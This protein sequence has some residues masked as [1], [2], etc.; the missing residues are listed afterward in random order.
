[1]KRHAHVLSQICRGDVWG[2][3]SYFTQLKRL[4]AALFTLE[5][6]PKGLSNTKSSLYVLTFR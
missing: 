6:A 1:M 5:Q 4:C 2:F 3:E